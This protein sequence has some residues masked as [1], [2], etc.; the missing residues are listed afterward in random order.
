VA[1]SE[2]RKGLLPAAWLG[3]V[4]P[5][6][7]IDVKPANSPSLVTKL[8][9]LFNNKVK[10]H[11][12][13]A[14]GQGSG[15]ESGQGSDQEAI[16]AHISCRD[17]RRRLEKAGVVPS[18]GNDDEED[19]DEDNSMEIDEVDEGTT[20][21]EDARCERLLRMALKG[22]P[23]GPN[24]RDDVAVYLDLPIDEPDTPQRQS[25]AK[26]GTLRPSALDLGC[27]H[28]SVLC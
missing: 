28:L 6:V 17:A 1:L 23:L 5:G 11:Y 7:G 18:R 12:E 2:L 26:K 16:L 25:T 27:V 8:N 10:Q 21:D 4:L 19:E 22:E 3:D 9:N 14:P 24:A 13:R 15:Q 20:D